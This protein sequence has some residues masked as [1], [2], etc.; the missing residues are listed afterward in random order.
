MVAPSRLKTTPIALV[1]SAA[2]VSSLFSSLVLSFELMT[3]SSMANGSD[4]NMFSIYSESTC[5]VTQS[6]CGTGCLVGQLFAFRGE[7][8]EGDG[9]PEMAVDETRRPKRIVFA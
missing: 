1:T 2:V 4:S 9:R 6:I 5:R 8:C 7:I 3:I